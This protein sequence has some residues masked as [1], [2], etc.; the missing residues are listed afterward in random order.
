MGPICTVPWELRQPTATSSPCRLVDC[1]VQTHG[2]SSFIIRWFASGRSSRRFR[3][4]R[5]EALATRP[6]GGNRCGIAQEAACLSWRS[7][8]L[9]QCGPAANGFSALAYSDR[10]VHHPSPDVQMSWFFGQGIICDGN[11]A[12]PGRGASASRLGADARPSEGRPWPYTESPIRFSFQCAAQLARFCQHQTLRPARGS[13][14]QRP[15]WIWPPF[16]LSDYMAASAFGAKWR[17]VSAAYGQMATP[18]RAGPITTCWLTSKVR[19][20]LVQQGPRQRSEA[21]R[22]SI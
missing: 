22:L 18:T 8:R 14:R 10:P 12:V 20:N 16:C 13:P 1:Q 4:P 11:V 6:D 15:R 7:E 5:L 19:L 21:G 17:H 3:D 2:N 9:M